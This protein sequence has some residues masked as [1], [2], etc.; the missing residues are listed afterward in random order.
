MAAFLGLVLLSALIAGHGWCLFKGGHRALG[1]GVLAVLTAAIVN[2]VV[3]SP[4]SV[5]GLTQEIQIAIVGATEEASRGAIL[6]LFTRNW[7]W[8]NAKLVA[9]ACGA[10]FATIENAFLVNIVFF[11]QGSQDLSNVTE[12]GLGALGNWSTG[13]T[14]GASWALVAVAIACALK[15]VF[16]VAFCFVGLRAL[17][18]NSTIG[19]LGVLVLHAF[20]NF[21]IVLSSSDH[22]ETVQLPLMAA[23]DGLTALGLL[24]LWRRL[25]V[26]EV[27]LSLG[28]E[29]ND[30]KLKR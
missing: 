19:F 2:A 6:Y 23:A 10:A 4:L 7:D 17:R 8:R 9:L 16:H 30:P 20:L 27:T 29:S 25:I 24:G 1:I 3:R 28:V 26:R 12:L 11:N 13:G 21:S 14:L 18:D 15:L 5:F 22:H